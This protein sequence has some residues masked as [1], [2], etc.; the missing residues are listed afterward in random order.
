MFPTM[1]TLSAWV[2][3]DKYITDWL[4]I[5]LILSVIALFSLF[6]SSTNIKLLKKCNVLL[7]LVINNSPMNR[8][9]I[10][11]S[12]YV[13]SSCV[14]YIPLLCQIWPQFM[15][16]GPCFTN[17]VLEWYKHM[18]QFSLNLHIHLMTWSELQFS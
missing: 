1:M 5:Q 18:F 17:K 10:S 11:N 9:S 3:P 15:Q 8:F 13:Q 7:S 4:T 14:K 6:L 12:T 2:L 16:K